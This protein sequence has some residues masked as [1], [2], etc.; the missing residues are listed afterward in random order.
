MTWYDNDRLPDDLR[1]VEERLRAHKPEV[2]ALELDRIKLRAMGQG[3]RAST[4]RQGRLGFMR[5]KLVTFA[6]VLGLAASGGT[7]GVIAGG[8]HEGGGKSADEGQY[9]SGKG[10]GDK[11]SKEHK[12]KCDQGDHGNGGGDH[13]NGGGDHGNGG[14]DH[15][16]GQGGNGNGGH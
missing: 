9:C 4:S 13:G 5:A 6:L 11:K 15:G 14:G 10:G 3:S 1:D 12:D 2:S 8:G 7:A 16:N